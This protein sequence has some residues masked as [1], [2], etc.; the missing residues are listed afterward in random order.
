MIEMLQMLNLGLRFLLELIV[1]TVYGFWGYRIGW[2]AWSSRAL[3]IGLP[4]SAAVLWGLL[5]SPKAT[6]AL[7]APLHQLLELMMFGLPVIL[8][9]RMNHPALAVLYGAVV[10]AN[11]VLMIVWNQ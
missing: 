2:S 11:K 1:L 4:L 9:F 5:G 8:L 3:C 6:F 7:P 10:L